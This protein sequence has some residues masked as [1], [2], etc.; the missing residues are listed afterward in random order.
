MKP[1]T[2]FRSITSILLLLITVTL[3]A[4][5]CCEGFTSIQRPV[6]ISKTYQLQ[7]QQQHGSGSGSRLTT[8]F[9]RTYC[10]PPTA[11]TVI[12][13]ETTTTTKPS[14]KTR[15]T[16]EILK[17]DDIEEQKDNNRDGWEIRLWND[18][19]NKREF[20]ARCLTTICNKSD[21]ESY[22]IMMQ[23]HK[24][25]MGV[26]GRYHFEIAEQYHGSLKENGLTVDMIQ[27]DDE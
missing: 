22:Q 12:E 9:A 21:T 24:N 2:S 4:S 20:V 1:A 16:I 10:T 6:S 18:P 5:S 14:K 17:D 11:S 7:H 26:I 19:F 23:A 25:G 8:V 3:L 13:E 15:K 27:V